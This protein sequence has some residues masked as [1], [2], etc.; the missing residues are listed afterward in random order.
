MLTAAAQRE[1]R[2]GEF[3]RRSL[4]AV[5]VRLFRMHP[6]TT[7]LPSVGIH[8]TDISQLRSTKMKSR[9]TLS[10]AAVLSLVAAV[11]GAQQKPG[12]AGVTP[13]TMPAPAISADSAKAIALAQ[14][15]GAT[16]TS[17]KLQSRKG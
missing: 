9:T 15:K 8:L 16:V 12:A 4:C 17:E 11:A 5:Q 1:A 3:L 6:F 13:K 2:Q 10:I 14:V 7:S